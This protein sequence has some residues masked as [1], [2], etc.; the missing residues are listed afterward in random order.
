V[1]GERG[2]RGYGFDHGRVDGLRGLAG[3][4]MRGA[5]CGHHRLE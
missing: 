4:V 1:R 5:R 3:N 2:R